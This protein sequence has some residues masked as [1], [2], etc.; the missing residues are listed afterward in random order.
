L[1]AGESVVRNPVLVILTIVAL[2]FSLGGCSK[3]G[4]WW[5]EGK[6]ASCKSDLPK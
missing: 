5:D 6:P 4:F 2:S 3:C 1:F